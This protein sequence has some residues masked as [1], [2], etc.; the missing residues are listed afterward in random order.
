MSLSRYGLE[1]IHPE[2]EVIA[3]DHELKDIPNLKNE[4]R[5]AELKP[6]L[7]YKITELIENR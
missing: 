4:L 7:Y 3:N 6:E 1:M 2:Y 5:P